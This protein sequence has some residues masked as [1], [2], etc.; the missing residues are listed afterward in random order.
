MYAS[1]MREAQQIGPFELLAT[2]L[3]LLLL[4]AAVM[5]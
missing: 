2:G 5:P 3:F 1:Q 4:V